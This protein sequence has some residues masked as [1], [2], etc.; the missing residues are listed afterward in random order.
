MSFPFGSFFL[1]G[2]ECA[3]HRKGDGTRLDMLANTRHD[4]ICR[5]DYELA[6]RH[7]IRGMRDGLRWHLIEEQRGFY[8]WSSLLPVLRAT[9]DLDV[10]IIWDLC[11]YGY[12]DWLDPWTEEFVESFARF[13]LAA[14]DI[15]AEETRRPLR[16]CPINE[17]SFWSWLGA[18]EGKIN[19]WSTGRAGDFKRHLVR[20]S[21]A[22]TRAIRKAHPDALFIS[23]EPLI[24]IVRDTNEEADILAAGGY[25]RAQFEATDLMLGYLSPEL[26]GSR[27]A[28]D[29][30]GVNYYPHNQW[31]I[32]G[33]FVPLGHHDYKPLRELL[34]EVYT[35]YGKPILLAET[36][37]EHSARPSW[38]NYVCREVRAAQKAQIPVSGICLYPVTNYTGWDNSRLCHAG[39]FSVPDDYG[40]RTAE[41]DLAQELRMQMDI[42]DAEGR[43]GRLK[44]ARNRTE[45][46]A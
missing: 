24:N 8:D 1:A 16:F 45:D 23:A 38:L 6:M 40:R 10:E 15:I 44:I 30:I 34:A 18:E 3:S 32:R 12:P 36:G 22:A 39:L 5:S 7:G 21:L 17:I 46:A 33:G 43:S 29:Y 14:A 25:H 4:E 2:F 26:G 27:D 19:P 41:P 28:I 35:R 11:H 42:F 20:A 9:R 37:A 13:A 31:R